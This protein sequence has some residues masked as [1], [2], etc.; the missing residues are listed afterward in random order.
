MENS[1]Q[2]YSNIPCE[3]RGNKGEKIWS[4]ATRML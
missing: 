1:L 3:E 4:P 2:K